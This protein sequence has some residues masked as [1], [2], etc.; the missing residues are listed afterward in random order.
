MLSR[1]QQEQEYQVI[2]ASRYM[3]ETKREALTAIVPHPDEK[4]SRLD[5]I[6]VLSGRRPNLYE[7]LLGYVEQEGWIAMS[8]KRNPD[9]SAG[10][11]AIKYLRAHA[12]SLDGFRSKQVV[13]IAKSEAA[14]V[15]QSILDVLKRGRNK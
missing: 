3:W 13:E 5:L 10:L 6:T 14:P 12:P 7:L 15:S 2:D 1:R 8:E 4:E 9:L 11:D